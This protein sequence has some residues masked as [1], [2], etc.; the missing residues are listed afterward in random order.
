MAGLE[1]LLKKWSGILFVLALTLCVCTEV[2]EYCEVGKVFDPQNQFCFDNKAYN[3]CGGSEYNPL[4]QVCQSEVVVPKN[5]PVTYAVIVSSVGT[6]ASGDSSYEAGSMVVVIAG[7]P[8]VGYR[9]ANWTSASDGIAFAN[10]NRDTTTFAMP[11]HAVTITANFEQIPVFTVTVFGAGADAD[12][13]RSGNYTAGEIVTVTAVSSSPAG[14]PFRNWISASAGV[15]FANANDMATTFIMPPNAVTVIA[16]FEPE[17]SS[18]IDLRDG[19][20]YG[21]VV[22]GGRTWMAE[23]LN[24]VDDNWS[25]NNWEGNVSAGIL[26][27]WCYSNKP[28]SCIKYGRLYTW[29]AAMVA[30]P[31][32]WSLPTRDDW[33]DLIQV[34]GGLLVAGRALKSESGWS[35]SPDSV[36][37]NGTDAHGFSALPGGARWN[38]GS[39]NIAAGKHAFWWSAT[40]TAGGQRFFGVGTFV[41]A[42]MM[43]RW[44][45]GNIGFSVRCIM[46]PVSAAA[47]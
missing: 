27:S 26:G 2:A 4:E 12:A 36:D 46:D 44:E 24:Y 45:P 16:N 17:R 30:C 15:T 31:A 34:A 28:D 29:D 23:N 7:T 32:G 18:F 3:K 20:S 41:F 11:P 47:N 19:K 35:S 1:R 5:P 33:N 14:Q 43:E 10:A 21:T 13:T 9:F 25:H 8:P 6:G 38:D 40:E 39:F 22:I 37:A 42:H